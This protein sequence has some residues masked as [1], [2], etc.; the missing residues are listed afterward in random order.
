[1]TKKILTI[2]LLLAFVLSAALTSCK[3]AAPEVEE[4]APEAEEAEAEEAEEEAAPEEEAELGS[5]TIGTNA[6]YPPF[7]FV[8]DANEITGFD[9][10]LMTAIAEEAGFEFEF[11]NTRW[12]GIFV[13][14]AS[15]EF[16][17]VISASTITEERAEMVNFSDPY[18]N[19][20]QRLA[21]RAGETEIQGPDDLA[22]KQVGVQLG[23][24][25]DIWLTDNTEAEVMRYDEN[26]LAFQALSSGD[27]DAAMADGP[28]AVDIIKANPEMN[29]KVLDGVYTEEQYGIAINKDQAALLEAINQGLAAIKDSG[30]YDEIYDK[31]FGTEVVAEEEA[32]EVAE[33]M[34]IELSE[35]AGTTVTFW[36]VWGT[37]DPGE[38]MTAIIDE[39]NA[40]NEYGITVEAVDQGHY[41]DAEDAFNAAIQSGDV[42]NAI[43][44]YTNALANWYSVDMIAD[45]QPYVEDEGVG[46]TDEEFADFYQGAFNGGVIADGTRIGIPLSQSVNVLFYNESWAQD[47]GFDDAPQTAADFKEQACAAAAANNNDD[48][49][50]NDGTGGLVLYAG[51]SNVMSWIFAYG[52]D[53]LTEDGS[54]Y[55]FATPAAEGVATL[56]KEMWDEG[57]AFATESYPNP[58]FATRKALFTMSSSAGLPFQLAA[59][60]EAGSDDDW[61]YIP[62]PGPDGEKAVDA[63]GQYVSVV[64]TTPAQKLA[65]WL[66]IKYF[67]SPEAQATWINASAY[68][69]VRMSTEDLLKD[70]I[71]AHPKWVTGLDLLEY[72]STEPTMSSWSSVRRAVSDTYEAILQGALGDIPTLL[73]ELNNIAAELVA[74]IEG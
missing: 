54:G 17:A 10:E 59:F 43:V 16:D 62:F 51:A 47:L 12:D 36:H 6:E 14:L 57:C 39:F 66:F 53:G 74:E 28:T 45:L 32:A 25:G 63:Y 21:V 18:F 46:F 70:Y 4:A 40:T 69:P 11:V 61:T 7:E 22:G 56:W 73:V 1:M 13:A 48:D 15:G 37:G 65:T 29:L 3:P 41:S 72:S 58:E 55:D 44:G 19:A 23:T 26:T 31:Y 20:G 42:P 30:Q 8:N 34:G 71:D 5:V 49:T 68:Y 24:T 27:I 52:D 60:D 35:L 33:A 50:D 2:I 38:G 64:E 67:I 9:I